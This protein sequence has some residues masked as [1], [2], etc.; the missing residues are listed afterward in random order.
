LTGWAQV[1]GR[2]DLGWDD[3]LALDAWYVA[4]LSFRLDAAI[5]ARTALAVLQ[6]RGVREHPAEIMTA[7]DEQRRQH[8]VNLVA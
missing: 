1:N 4:H 3:R 6:R 5:L 7:L 8:A 2:N